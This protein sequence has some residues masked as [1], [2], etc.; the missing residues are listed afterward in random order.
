[1]DKKDTQLKKKGKQHSLN[2]MYVS[3][4]YHVPLYVHVTAVSTIVMTEI[5]VYQWIRMLVFHLIVMFKE[6]YEM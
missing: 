1:M 5:L 4:H 6:F 2:I 3:T